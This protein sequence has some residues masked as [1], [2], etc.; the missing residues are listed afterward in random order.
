MIHKTAGTFLASK[1]AIPPTHGEYVNAG[2]YY[3]SGERHAFLFGTLS[4]VCGLDLT[5]LIM[6]PE[7][8]WR[9][10]GGYPPRCRTCEAEAV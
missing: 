4:T 10:G 8:D 6:F 7:L 5:T 1:T 2:G 3:L 9:D